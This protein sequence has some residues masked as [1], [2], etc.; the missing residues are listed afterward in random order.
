MYHPWRRLREASDWLVAWA[1]LP[2]GIWGFTDHDARVIVLDGDLTQAQRRCTIAHEL[3]HIARGPVPEDPIL[4]AKEEEAI[5]RA[6]ARRLI[7]LA[8]WLD[9][10]RWSRDPHEIADELWVDVPTLEARIRGLH[11]SERAALM[12]ALEHHEASA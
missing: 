3:E 11:P 12:R 1:A 4:L 9:A 8:K 5:D 6:V 7:P 10:V 2:A